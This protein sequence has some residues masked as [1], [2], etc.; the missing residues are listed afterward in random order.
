MTAIY[1]YFLIQKK[2][3]SSVPKLQVNIESLQNIETINIESLQ[4]NCK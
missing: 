4:K 1:C 2:K 3:N